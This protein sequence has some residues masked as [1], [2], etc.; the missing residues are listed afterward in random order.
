MLSKVIYSLAL[1]GAATFF[2]P[3]ECDAAP[4][5]VGIACERYS[6]LAC[7][8]RS[9]MIVSARVERYLLRPGECAAVRAAR[10]AAGLSV[11]QACS[12]LHDFFF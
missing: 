11:L 2:A 12:E 5:S 4:A 6:S 9:A 10:A 1:Q 3:C 8:S 7:N